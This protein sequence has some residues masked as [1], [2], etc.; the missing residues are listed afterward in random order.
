MK[1]PIFPVC[2]KKTWC[3]WDGTWINTTLFEFLR[4]GSCYDNIFH[5]EKY[6]FLLE[7]QNVI[8]RNAKNMG[9]NMNDTVLLNMSFHSGWYVWEKSLRFWEYEQLEFHK[10][11]NTHTHVHAY[12]HANLRLLTWCLKGVG[13]QVWSVKNMK[14][15][16]V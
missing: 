4:Y 11:M 3:E 5:F 1:N 12:K 14:C 6:W 9:G 15:W 13:V 16:F 10:F 8:S 7:L 2:S